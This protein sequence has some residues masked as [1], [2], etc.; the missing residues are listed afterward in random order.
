MNILLVDDNKLSLNIIA[1]MASEAGYHIITASSPSQALS[2]IEQQPISLILMD[3]EMP[4]MN[5]FEL[6][7]IIRQRLT[8]WLPII[9]L[10]GNSS[11]DYIAK[12]ID[13]GGD[14][15]L[16]KPVKKVILLAKIRAMERIAQMKHA[17]DEANKKLEQ[18]SQLD[19]LTGL[20]NRRALDLYLDREWHAYQ[21]NGSELSLLM[22]DIDHFKL[23]NDHYGHQQGDDC[24]KQVANLI[25]QTTNRSTDIAARYGGEEFVLLL[26]HTP[27]IGARYKAKEILKRLAILAIEHQPSPISSVVSISIG[28]ASTDMEPETSVQLI[29]FADQALYHAKQQGR[30][31][32]CVYGG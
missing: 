11:E 19:G 28:I 17:L 16:T 4:E 30:N 8:D 5:G 27:L 21:R 22:L 10:S 3:I 6:T 2:I 29:N 32:A 15:Y 26:P 14:D 1:C 18:L 25:D 7:R 23:F 9:F 12:G 13:A 20:F 31:S 24:L